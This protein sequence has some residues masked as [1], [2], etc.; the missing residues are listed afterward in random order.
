MKISIDKNVLSDGL[1]KVQNAVSNRPAIPVLNNILITA[2]DNS[3]TITGNDMNISITTTI[4]CNVETEGTTTLP[5]RKFSQIIKQ[6]PSDVVTISTDDKNI[7]SISCQKSFFKIS[8]LSA[9]DYPVLE[10]DGEY[11]QYTT[12][13]NEFR[14]A[15]SKID[16]ASSADE[17]RRVLNGILLSIRGNTVT[18]VATDGRRLALIESHIDDNRDLDGDVIL[19]SQSVNELQKLLSSGD[20]VDV[21]LGANRARFEVGDTILTAK[22]IEG[23]YP[24]FNQVVP[25]EFGNHVNIKR[26]LLADSINRV[27]VIL[28]NSSSPIKMSL[29]QGKAV[30][31]ST[32]NADESSE[33]IDVD[34]SGQPVVIALNPSFIHDTLK[35]LEC[36]AITL[37]FTDNVSPICLLGD[38]G[39]KYIIMPMRG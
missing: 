30:I 17:T 4:D 9:V 39:F 37:K 24:N 26:S 31:Q 27:S 22:L 3:L 1:V 16:Y 38:E 5:A 23:N 25:T 6:L 29:E 15:L 36:E 13:S 19:T 10:G 12:S 14:K 20:S 35:R 28:D 7:S 32:S 8:G 33:P 34:Y 21:S 18:A 2:K 11:R